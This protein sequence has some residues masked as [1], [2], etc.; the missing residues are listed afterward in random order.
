MDP[1]ASAVPSFTRR[2][3]FAA[4]PFAAL[5]LAGC[6]VGATGSDS[7]TPPVADSCRSL[8]PRDL[9][10]PSNASPV[11]SCETRHT[12]E[13][14]AVGTFPASLTGA[15]QPDDQGLGAWISPVCQ[16]KFE[17]FTGADDS[18]ALRATITWAWFRASDQAWS[19]GAHWWRCDT[20]GGGQQST[21]LQA[22]PVTA[23]GLFR[24]RPADRWLLC[25]D[26]PTVAGSPKVPCSQPHTW[27]AVTTIVLG[28]PGDPY[29]GDRTV[30]LRT[31]DYCNSSVG[32]WLN[33]PVGYDY[34]YTWFHETEWKTGNRRSICWAKTR[35]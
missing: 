33:Y 11:V 7:T 10:Q 35:Q 6:Q 2:R 30:A 20:V 1:V 25:A 24:G 3:W 5:A 4:L 9:A 22:L 13:T 19:K 8:G 26:G 14:Y 23:R 28:K 34:G 29:P 18:L 31:R 15:R 17:E 21:A 27:R 32:A 12:A 16:K